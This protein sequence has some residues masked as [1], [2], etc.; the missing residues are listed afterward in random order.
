MPEYGV[1]A[2]YGNLRYQ[3]WVTVLATQAQKHIVRRGAAREER[4]QTGLSI[5]API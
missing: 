1:S 4:L 5:R 2:R 3:A